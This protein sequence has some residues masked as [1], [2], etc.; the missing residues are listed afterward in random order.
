MR[1][2]F[3][4]QTYGSVA[5]IGHLI[6]TLNRGHPDNLVVIVHNGFREELQEL[7]RKHRVDQD[8]PAAHAWEGFGAIDSYISALRWLHRQENLYDWVIL[9]SGKDYPIRPL[10]ELSKTLEKSPVDG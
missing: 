5:Q 6:N 10:T 7:M 3:V 1:I 9:L 8:I 4:I 2:A